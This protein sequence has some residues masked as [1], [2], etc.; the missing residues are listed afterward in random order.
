MKKHGRFG[1]THDD[2]GFRIPK[3]QRRDTHGDHLNEKRL[4]S[5][6]RSKHLD[7]LLDEDDDFDDPHWLF[8]DKD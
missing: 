5:T 1:R 7:A 2:E 8:R 6:L 4:Q 3:H